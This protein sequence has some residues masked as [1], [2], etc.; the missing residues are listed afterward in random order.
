[1]TATYP[2]AAC[3]FEMH[4]PDGYTAN[5]LVYAATLTS[6]DEARRVFRSTRQTVMSSAG[7][8]SGFGDE[9]ETY[10]RDWEPGFK[11]SEYKINIRSGN[12][13]LQVWLSVGGTAFTPAPTLA[14]KAQTVAKT[15]LALIPRV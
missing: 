4:T 12:L 10:T 6:V 7:T 5:L 9:T 11:Y 3:L 14:A 1:M 13:V 2:G 15:T 8:V